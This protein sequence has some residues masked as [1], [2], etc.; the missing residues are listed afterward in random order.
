M[1]L[2]P[3]LHTFLPSPSP[4]YCSSSSHR[5]LLL[6]SKISVSAPRISHFSNSFS[7]IRRWN[8]CSASSSETLVAGSRKENGKTGEAVTKKEDDEFGDLKAWMHDNGL[9]PCKVI[10]EEKPSHDKNHRPIHYV[11]ASEDLEV[12]FCRFF[13]RGFPFN[14]QFDSMVSWW[15]FLWGYSFSGG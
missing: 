7:P 6:L 4:S 12:N 13:I 2:S 11:A 3:L 9:P 10:L 5:P 1:D 15:S 14:C 8:V